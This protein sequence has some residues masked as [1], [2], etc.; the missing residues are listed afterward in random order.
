M[1][2]K[3]P[4]RVGVC[5][6]RC[7]GLECCK[8][9]GRSDLKAVGC[10]SFGERFSEPCCIKSRVE[11]DILASH[12]QVKEAGEKCGRYSPGW[13]YKPLEENEE[14]RKR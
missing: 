1:I 5:S 6:S 9:C 2:T 4:I 10:L 11:A 3:R 12:G 13:R 8:C 7:A 14:W